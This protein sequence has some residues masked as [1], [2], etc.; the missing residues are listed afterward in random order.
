MSV[1]DFTFTPEQELWLSTLE[2]TEIPQATNVL[3]DICTGG[4]CC[5]GIGSSLFLAETRETRHGHVY[6]GED[7]PDD[8]EAPIELVERLHLRGNSGEVALDYLPLEVKQ[9]L[10]EIRPGMYRSA[11]AAFNDHGWTFKQI[12]AFCRAHPKAVFTNA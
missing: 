2:T 8:T 5:L 7:A 1:A 10:P 12:A 11:L 4:M 9:A 3:E 6:Y